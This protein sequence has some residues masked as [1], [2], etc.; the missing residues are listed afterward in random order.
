MSIILSIIGFVNGIDSKSNIEEAGYELIRKGFL[1]AER[2]VIEVNCTVRIMKFQDA[3]NGFNKWNN[4][5]AIP[6]LYDY[7]KYKTKTANF[8]CA[9]QS[10]VIFFFISS[11]TILLLHCCCIILILQKCILYI[12]DRIKVLLPMNENLMLK[13]QTTAFFL[14]LKMRLCRK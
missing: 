13:H 12:Y 1:A 7:L 2:P 5:N 11:I 6:Q 9:N 4:N 3:S 14:K 8:I 10:F